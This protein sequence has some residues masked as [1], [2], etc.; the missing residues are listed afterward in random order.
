MKTCQ[1]GYEGDTLFCQRC[2]K[3]LSDNPFVG[4]PEDEL[5][6]IRVSLAGRWNDI[7]ANITALRVR[8][9]KL[10]AEQSG[11]SKESEQVDAAL[12]L[13]KSRRGAAC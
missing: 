11:I 12:E 5:L 2:G 9:D 6:R 7:M 8:I 3:R 13:L 4:T 10:S 1:C